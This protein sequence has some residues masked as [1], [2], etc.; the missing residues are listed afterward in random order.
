MVRVTRFERAISTSQ[1]W[2]G[3]SSAT[4]GYL[5]V[6]IIARNSRDSKFFL[7]VGKHMVKTVFWPGSVRN[8]NPANNCAARVSSLSPLRSSDETT[9]LPKQ[10]RYQL[11]YT[12]IC[13]FL[14]FTEKYED[15]KKFS[16]FYFVIFLHRNSEAIATDRKLC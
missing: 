14:Y 2:R 13:C 11:R 6:S 10:A 3:T 12:R 4:P 5:I 9:A 1:M 8:T 16:S 7:T 15:V